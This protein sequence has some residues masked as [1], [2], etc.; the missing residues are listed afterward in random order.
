MNWDLGLSQEELGRN[1]KLIPKGKTQCRIKF[2]SCG[3]I[4]FGSVLWAK[5]HTWKNM[6]AEGRKKNHQQGLYLSG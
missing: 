6:G 4:I 2:E 3:R 1:K 5:K